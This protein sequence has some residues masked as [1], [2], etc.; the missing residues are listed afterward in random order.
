MNKT[1]LIVDD[2]ATMRQMVGDTLRH[3]GFQVL[4]GVHGEDGLK[5]L[6]GSQV[7]LVITDYNMPVMGG[8]AFIHK[9]RARA[10]NKFTPILVLT[11]ETEE[12]RK[13]EAR[14]AGA[15][16]WLVKPFDPNRLIQVVN[17]LVP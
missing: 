4:E 7:N 12:S 16:G 14:A 8:I 2:S 17:R 5:K 9:M 1:I 15:T 3:A 13:N 6:Q 11:T 10:E